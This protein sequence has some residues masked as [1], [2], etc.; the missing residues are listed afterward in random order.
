M[1]QLKCIEPPTF[2]GKVNTVDNWLFS[3]ELYFRAAG[4]DYENSDKIKACN[5][6]CALFRDLAL[7]WYKRI[8]RSSLCPHDYNNL[9]ALLVTQFATIDESRRARDALMSLK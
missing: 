7:Q 4:I 3:L 6:A 8:S 5:I 2:S 9:K 1:S